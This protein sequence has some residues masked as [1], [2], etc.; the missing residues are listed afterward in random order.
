MVRVGGAS[1]SPRRTLIPPPP[2]PEVPPGPAWGGS[3]FSLWS[4]FSK[5]NCRGSLSLRRSVFRFMVKW[6]TKKSNHRETAWQPEPAWGICLPSVSLSPVT[7]LCTGDP[8]PPEAHVTS[9]GIRNMGVRKACEERRQHAVKDTFQMTLL[10]TDFMLCDFISFSICWPIYL[11]PR[12]KMKFIVQPANQQHKWTSCHVIWQHSEDFGGKRKPSLSQETKHCRKR[13]S[14]HTAVFT[15]NHL[16]LKMPPVTFICN[17]NINCNVPAFLNW[18]YFL[19][20][21]LV[22]QIN[23]IWPKIPS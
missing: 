21:F 4:R 1:T 20:R 10:F 5:G 15:H 9:S 14:Q 3:L 17:R 7:C 23:Y 2:I 6:E 18:P 8:C 11:K 19:N 22:L 12:K 16:I 13:F